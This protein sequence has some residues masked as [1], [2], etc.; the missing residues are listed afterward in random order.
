MIGS[1]PFPL[2]DIQTEF[3][4]LDTYMLAR[5]EQ[6]KNKVINYYENYNFQLALQE[7]LTFLSTDLS[8]FYLDFAK[9]ILY[10]NDKKSK[11][12]LQIQTVIFNCYDTLLRLLNPIIPFTMDEALNSFNLYGAK[13]AQML[14]FPKVSHE[15]GEEIL[16]EYKWILKLRADVL[17]G[18]EIVRRNNEIGSAQQASVIIEVKDENNYLDKYYADEFAKLFIVSS[19]RVVKNLEDTTYEGEIAKVKVLKAEGIKCDRCWN[20]VDHTFET[21]EGEHICERCHG[22]VNE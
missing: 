16:N 20:I 10:C 4:P 11:R 15:Y 18:I 8:S 12:R 3:E 19:A 9:D 22:V 17:K 5:L 14:D 13:N 7:I 1:I 2:D 21:A 6:V